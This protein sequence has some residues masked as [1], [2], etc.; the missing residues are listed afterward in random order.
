[1]NDD[2]LAHHLVEVQGGDFPLALPAGTGKAG[3][4]SAARPSSARGRARV[5]TLQGERRADA[6]LPAPTWGRQRAKAAA[7]GKAAAKRDGCQRHSKSR[8]DGEGPAPRTQGEG[9][10]LTDDQAAVI[11]GRTRLPPRSEPDRAKP[12][13]QLEPPR[14]ADRRSRHR[15]Q[16]PTSSRRQG[17]RAGRPSR[18]AGQAGGQRPPLTSRRRR[19]PRRPRQPAEPSRRRCR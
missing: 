12:A 15:R 9:V 8:H 6:A 10:E 5:L 16:R 19:L 4:L 17:G 7:P 2:E 14:G 13:V 1:M 11:P 3:Q 18:R